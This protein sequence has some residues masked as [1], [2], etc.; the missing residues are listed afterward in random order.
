MP[1]GSGAFV[2][3]ATEAGAVE[4]AVGKLALEKATSPAVKAFA[5]RMVADHGQANEELTRLAAEQSIKVSDASSAVSK[6]TAKLSPLTGAQFDREYMEMQVAAHQNAVVLFEHEVQRAAT[7]RSKRLQRRRCGRSASIRRWR[8][9]RRNQSASKGTSDFHH[10]P[11]AADGWNDELDVRVRA[12]NPRFRL[13]PDKL[14]TRSSWTNDGLESDAF[15]SR[16]R[17]MA[18]KAIDPL[19][20]F[21]THKRTRL[22]AIDRGPHSLVDSHAGGAEGLDE[23]AVSTA[24][25]L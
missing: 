20:A 19:V 21:S 22:S 5:T 7:P 10:G 11:T 14:S 18:A 12:M 17:N 4:V 8:T 13:A 9:R 3:K 6:A 24:T 16:N 25:T 15:V 23:A 2:A 1:E